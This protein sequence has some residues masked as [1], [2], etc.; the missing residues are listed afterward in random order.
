MSVPGTEFVCFERGLGRKVPGGATGREHVPFLNVRQVA[1]LGRRADAVV[2]G[3]RKRRGE[4]IEALW[5]SVDLAASGMPAALGKLGC[6][7][8]TRSLRS[9]GDS[10]R[11]AEI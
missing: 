5:P 10:G 4:E 3:L 8:V 2:S 11:V 1:D 6:S 9:V 7:R